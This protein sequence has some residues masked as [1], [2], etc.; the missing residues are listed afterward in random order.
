MYTMPNDLGVEN[1][2]VLLNKPTYKSKTFSDL[3]YLLTLLVHL[4]IYVEIILMNAEIFNHRMT[5]VFMFLKQSH[6]V[7]RLLFFSLTYLDDTVTTP[8]V[9]IKFYTT[10]NVK[11][12]SPHYQKFDGYDL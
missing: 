6:Y 12:E 5:D 4:K 10:F 9:S 11:N 3:S 8:L 2:I 7:L 1:F